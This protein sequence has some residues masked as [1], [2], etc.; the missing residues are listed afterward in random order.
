MCKLNCNTNSNNSYTKSCLKKTKVT[1]EF[2]LREDG[3]LISLE[4]KKSPSVPLCEREAVRHNR[5]SDSTLF[6]A[7]SWWI[8]P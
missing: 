4:N 6:T 5:S 2:I 3:I 1:D 8:L 7:V